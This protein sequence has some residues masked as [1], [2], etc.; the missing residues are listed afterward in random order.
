MNATRTVSQ[1]RFD[2]DWLRVILILIVLVF[3]T[4]RFFD[5]MDWHVKNPTT[6]PLVQL[7][8]MFLASWMM[9]MIFI[10]S[11]ASLFYALGKGG[12]GKFAKDKVLR[13]VVPLVVGVFT[14]IPLA[15]YLERLTHHMTVLP[16]FQWLPQYFNGLYGSG[17]GNFA[18]MGLHLWYLLV[19]FVFSMVFLPVF[20]VLKGPGKKVLHWLGNVF[21]FPGM[22]YLLVLPVVLVT[23]GVSPK[24]PL[25]DRNWGGWSLLGYIPVFLYGFLIISHDGLQESIRKQRWVSLGL[26][27]AATAGLVYTGIAYG[28][29]PYG[30]RGYNLFNGAFGLDAWL[31]SLV[32]LGFGLKRLNF[33]TPFLSY[34]NEA[35][36]PFYVL[37]QTVLLVV[38]YF[39][40]RWQIP[41]PIKFLVVLLVSFVFIMVVYEFIIRR[42]NVLRVLFGMKAQ[43][44]QQ[45][46]EAAIK[47]DLG[48]I[49]I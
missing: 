38:G 47:P 21:A 29:F 30:T 36:M 11:G 15:V 2:L 1:R 22:V 26:A 6:S 37:H 16:F 14:Q 40:T 49:K 3:H 7:W 43:S 45:L 41:D 28:G 25:G 44:R 32:I 10:I 9:P 27:V 31:C 5:T 20:L 8:T 48:G 13:L 12:V 33:T 24:A 17:S 34:A 42:I 19:L 4:G 18:W 39:V 46:A 35:V 23:V